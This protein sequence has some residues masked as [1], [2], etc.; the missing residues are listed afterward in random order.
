MRKVRPI[1]SSGLK[2]G[3]DDWLCSDF[4]SGCV[5]K[6]GL[7]H[8]R[9]IFERSIMGR[10]LPSRHASTHITIIRSFWTQQGTID[11]DI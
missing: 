2:V 5:G 1:R 3:E 9:S 10:I 6:F 7:T 8:G 4:I 11:D